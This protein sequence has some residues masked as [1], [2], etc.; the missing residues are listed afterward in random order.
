MSSPFRSPLAS[1]APRC[2][3]EL[4]HA[5]SLPRSLPMRT[6]VRPI[7][8]N[9]IEFSDIPRESATQLVEARDHGFEMVPVLDSSIFHYFLYPLALEASA[10]HPEDRV[11][12]VCR[13]FSAN[14]C[15]D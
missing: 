1:D 5:N 15:R 11:V 6:S 4:L 14:A 3:H 7:L 9:L 12:I 10:V 8:N 13:E 2:G